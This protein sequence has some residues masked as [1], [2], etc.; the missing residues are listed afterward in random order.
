VR[1]PET[2]EEVLNQFR[3]LRGRLFRQKELRSLGNSLHSL[4]VTGPEMGEGKTFITLNLGLMMAVAPGCRVL[5][6]DVNVRRPAFPERL[7]LGGF[8]LRQALDGEPWQQ[9]ARRCKGMELYVMPLGPNPHPESLD[10]IDLGRLRSWLREQTEH[11]DWILL[12]GPSL[13]ESPDAEMLARACD[14]SLLVLRS[15]CTRFRRLHESLAR[16]EGSAVS[17]A[18]FNRY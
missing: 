2:P 9:V 1:Y 4:L 12:D 7:G 6:V 14:S 5:V 8:G 17:G 13:N 11:F 10:P 15:G 18:V 16:L 3:Q